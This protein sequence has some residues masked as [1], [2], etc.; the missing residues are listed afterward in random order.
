[1][2]EIAVAVV[3]GAAVAVVAVA[4][5]AVAVVAVLRWS[6]R[7]QSAVEA[8]RDEWRQ[9]AANASVAAR[10][11]EQLRQPDDGDDSGDEWKNAG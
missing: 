4:P 1:M 10:V 5:A 11:L 7:R 2:S 6:L 9:A 3:V 8:D